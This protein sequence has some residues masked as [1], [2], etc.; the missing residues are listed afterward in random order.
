MGVPQAV[1]AGYDQALVAVKA[2]Q[3]IVGSTVLRWAAG[4]DYLFKERIKTV[5]ST[6]EKIESGRFDSWRML[7]DLYACT[8]VVPTLSHVEGVVDFLEAAFETYEIRGQGVARKPPDVFRFDSTR[9]I[10]RLRE[11][12]GGDRPEGADAVLFEVQILTAFE[13]AWSVATHDLVYKGTSVDW[14]RDRLAAH[15]RAAAEEA[16]ILISSF[17]ETAGAIRVS[18]HADTERVE[19]IIG[20]FRG[21]LEKG[22]LPE[23]L[24]PLS[25]VRFGENVLELVKSFRRTTVDNVLEGVFSETAV[26][27]GEGPAPRTGSLFQLVVGVIIRSHGRNALRGFVVIDSSELRDFYNVQSVP[28]AFVFGEQS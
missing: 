15:L 5:S 14:R 3:A 7:D 2:V 28:K 21:E 1:Q 25:W 20:Y 19:R 17:E 4:N 23:S 22:S 24:E 12:E 18:P 11:Q 10:G 27:L 8:V 13:Y 6:A 26:M 9:F 16:D